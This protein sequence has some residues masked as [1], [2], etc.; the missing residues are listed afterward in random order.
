LHNYYDKSNPYAL[1]LAETE[2]N[3]LSEKAPQTRVLFD[4]KYSGAL[5]YDK[6]FAK[7]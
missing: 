2:R 7:N 1:T 4:E 6:Q 3:V 5:I